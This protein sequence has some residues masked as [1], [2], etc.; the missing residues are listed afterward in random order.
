MPNHEGV[1]VGGLTCPCVDVS[2]RTAPEVR[3]FVNAYQAAHGLTPAIYAAEAWDAARALA[4][5]LAG[6]ASDRG[7]VAAWLSALERVDGVARV[8]TFDE[9]GELVDPRVHLYVAA[10]SRWLRVGD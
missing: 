6:G 3:S 7:Q 10:G 8:Y 4:G 5:E 9:R 2:T 1:V